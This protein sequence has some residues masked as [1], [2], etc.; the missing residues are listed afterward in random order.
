VT[1]GGSKGNPYATGSVVEKTKK[2]RTMTIIAYDSI[3]G[4]D[5]Q[6]TPLTRAISGTVRAPERGAAL[7]R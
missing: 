6:L 5:S 3:R 1:W 7:K 4:R 2:P